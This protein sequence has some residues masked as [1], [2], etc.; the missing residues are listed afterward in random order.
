MG[1]KLFSQRKE[2]PV[3]V[4]VEDSLSIISNSSTLLVSSAL[5]EQIIE[6]VTVI[7]PE[8]VTVIEPEHVT[9]IAPEPVTVI[10]PEHVTVIEPEHVT[11]IEPE[12]VTVIAHGIDTSHVIIKNDFENISESLSKSLPIDIPML[13][14]T[15]HVIKPAKVYDSEVYD[16]EVGDS[17]VDDSEVGDSEVDDS[18]VDDLSRRSTTKKWGLK[19]PQNSD[20]S[21]ISADEAVLGL[22]LELELESELQLQE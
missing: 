14:Q 18:E 8:H 12:P 22:E 5:L 3:C 11:V 16:S 17:E 10:E 15:S 1:N 7:E 21:D 20:E 2:K 4:N 13:E 6:H 9:V 19:T